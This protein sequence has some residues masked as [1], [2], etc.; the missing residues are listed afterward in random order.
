[1]KSKP[2]VFLLLG[3]I[4]LMGINFTSAA[5]VQVNMN[6][7][8]GLQVFYP[9][10]DSVK[11]DQGFEL[12]IHVSNL[13]NGYPLTN[14]VVDCYLHL[15][16]SSGDHTYENG[17]MDKDPDL[18]DHELFLGGGNFS[19]LGWHSYYIWCN[20]TTLG[21]SAKGTFQVT[22]TGE[23]G[24]TSK[25]VFYVGILFL[26]AILLLISIYGFVEAEQLW[27]K[28]GLVGIAYLFLIAISFISWNMTSNFMTSSPFI[29]DFLRIIFLVLTIAFF[30]LMI[31]LFV[32]G[33]WMML[34][35]E[36][37]KKLQE[38]GFTPEEASEKVKKRRKF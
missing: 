5:A 28:V 33:V 3:M 1:M 16:N 7:Q 14:D 2:F 19:D 11:Q 34:Q 15:Y 4:F 27:A 35:I 9:D 21:G 26:L 23:I 36:E 12:H 22:P 38:Q 29:I 10:F 6:S 20:S 18:I 30:P 8:E 17:V 32:Y 37:I 31:I 24:T 13:S 25:A